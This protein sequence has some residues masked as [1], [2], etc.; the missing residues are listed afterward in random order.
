[1]HVACDWS[2]PLFVYRHLQVQLFPAHSQ[3]DTKLINNPNY[4]HT[5]PYIAVLLSDYF[6]FCCF[7]LMTLSLYTLGCKLASLNF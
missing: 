6:D 4:I 2:V 3:I 7:K 5:S 1:M